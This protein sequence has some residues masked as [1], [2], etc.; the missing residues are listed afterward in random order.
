V[1]T[2]AEL[3]EASL[4][5]PDAFAEIFDRHARRVYA[6]AGSRLGHDRAA[7]ITTDVFSAAFEGRARFDPQVASAL[8]WLLGITSHLISRRARAE[9]RYLRA[10]AKLA[11]GAPVDSTDGLVDRVDAVRGRAAVLEEVA[12]LSVG[13]REVLLLFAWEDLTY[14]E[15]AAA[16]D[17]PLG[18]VQSRLH[19]ARARLR[20]RL[21]GRSPFDVEDDHA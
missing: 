4:T 9:V 12:A 6:Y 20:R 21:A 15:I 2:D 16:L 14:L 18:T 11:P 7:E 19:R 3:I 17:I 13:E 5:D 1:R 8:P 10:V